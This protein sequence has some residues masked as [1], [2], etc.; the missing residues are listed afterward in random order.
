MWMPPLRSRPSLTLSVSLSLLG[1]IPGYAVTLHM[2]RRVTASVI[3]SRLRIRLFMFS[4]FHQ[5]FP[6]LTRKGVRTRRYR[7]FLLGSLQC[8]NGIPRKLDFDVFRYSKLNPVVFESHYRT[9]NPT[10]SDDLIAG[11]QVVDHFLKLLLTASCREKNNQVK[12]AKD[13]DER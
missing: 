11:L 4:L 13:E 9:V 8:R 1:I 2:H 3:R 6:D 5:H 7:L 12:D 10:R